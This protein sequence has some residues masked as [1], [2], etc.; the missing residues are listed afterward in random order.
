[1]QHLC[2]AFDQNS[3]SLSLRNLLDTIETNAHY[4]EQEGFRERLKDDPFV[5]SLAATARRPDPVPFESDKR[6]V[7]A[8][9]NPLVKTLMIW[10]NLIVAHRDAGKI[11][12]GISLG[13]QHPLSFADVQTLLDT[14]LQIVNRYSILFIATSHLKT[15]I[16]HDDY[17]KVLQAIRE[18]LTS[19]EARVTAEIKQF[20]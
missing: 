12:K 1:M 4:F 10:R 8:D 16:G 2:K 11:L 7:S 6:S 15:M 19:S 18:Q 13:K 3:R 5:E 17:L 20:T 14:G 9:A